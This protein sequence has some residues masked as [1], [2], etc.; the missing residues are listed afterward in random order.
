MRVWEVERTG[1]GLCPVVVLWY[2]YMLSSDRVPHSGRHHRS[3]C[4]VDVVRST[5][6]SPVVQS[7]YQRVVWY[8]VRSLAHLPSVC[9]LIEE[10]FCLSAF[11]VTIFGYSRFLKRS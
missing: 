5:A 4:N 2:T 11:F 10:P 7:C 9:R 3:L 8:C 1:R 6:S